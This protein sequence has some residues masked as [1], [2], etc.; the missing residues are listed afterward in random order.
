MSRFA[1]AAIVSLFLVCNTFGSP[2]T[3]EWV[4]VGD[5][6]NSG[7][8]LTFTGPVPYGAVG[9]EYRIGK[10][11]V[12]NE[13]YAVFLNAVAQSDP[14]G[15]Y[16]TNMG[17]VIVGGI[18]RSG[19]DGSYVYTVKPN[20]GEKPVNLVTWYSAARMANWMTNGQPT[21]PQSACTTESG[22]YTLTGPSTISAITRDATNPNQVFIPT[23]NEWYKAAYHQPANQGGDADGF[24]LYA[25]RSNSV[26]TIANAT[27]TGGVANPGQSV[28][29]YYSGADWNGQNGNV[30]SVGSAGSVT[31]YG[32]FDM[33]GNVFEWSETPS[34]SFG[35]RVYRGGGFDGV[36][37]P[38]ALELQ[39][40]SR[41]AWNPT[42][43]LANLGYRLA[44][45]APLPEPEPCPCDRDGDG[46]GNQTV[47]DY[48][49]FLTAF[50][51]Q[52]NMAGSADIDGDGTVTVADYF[53]F[54]SC[55]PA[56]AASTPCP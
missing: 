47:G 31:F 1:F 45:P 17:L 2:V 20:M 43:E 44:S 40:P 53:Q 34:G 12:T 7:D 4:T 52:L 10:F 37:F 8:P 9:Y 49:A 35:N 3:I 25:T 28:A 46:D 54:L 16:N 6:G 55:L 30:T 13:Q 27:S 18:T 14:N 21:G 56:I 24:W 50:F 32:A 19:S 22:V 36:P 48:F 29:N 11:E 51:A 5:P 26:P 39:S 15:L 41:S 23:E 33:N 42:F 38:Q